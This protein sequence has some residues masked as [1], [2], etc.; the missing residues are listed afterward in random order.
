MPQIVLIIFIIM[1]AISFSHMPLKEYTQTLLSLHFFLLDK[2]KN[3][4]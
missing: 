1:S 3:I 2:S 4:L